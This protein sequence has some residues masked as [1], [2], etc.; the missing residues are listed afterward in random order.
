[1][2][3]ASSRSPSALSSLPLPWLPV[4]LQVGLVTLG[5]ACDAHVGEAGLLG[6]GEADDAERCEESDG[7]AKSEGEGH[8][9]LVPWR[10][11]GELQFAGCG[12]EPT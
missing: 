4:G 2:P 7:D 12:L 9:A 6:L 10:A 11:N 5:V 1:M 8:G 3:A